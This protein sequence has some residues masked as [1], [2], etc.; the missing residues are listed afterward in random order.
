MTYNDLKKQIERFHTGEISKKELAIVV[1]MW[2]RTE[3]PGL[4]SL[5]W[6]RK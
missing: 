3:S 2:Q 4:A 6:E 5:R 1:A